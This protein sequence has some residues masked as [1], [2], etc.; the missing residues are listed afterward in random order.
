MYRT[1]RGYFPIMPT[2]YKEDGEVDLVSMRRLTDFLVENGA[3]G[4]SPNGGD[5]EARHLS[6]EERMR[7]TDVVLEANAGRT[8]VLVGTTAH[9]LEESARLTRHAQQAGAD[10]V[11]VMPSWDAWVSAEK[12]GSNKEAVAG[13]HETML[14]R[15]EEICQGLDIPVM[16]HA[17]RGMDR[18]FM[19]AVIE[20]VPNVR[21]IKEETSHGRVLREYVAELGDRVVIFGPGL[22]Y[23][24]E[25]G[26]GALGVMPSCCAPG[27]HARVFDLWQEGR[28]DEARQEWNRLLPL[29]FWRWHTS[30]Q[31][32]GKLYLQEL[33]I[34]E[35]S[36]VRP[37]FGTHRLDEADREE[38][39]T[40]LATMGV[41]DR[42]ASA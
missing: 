27:L 23:P 3:Q 37:T 4:M 12:A 26:W 40:V 29:V 18:A 28:H 32:A 22:H 39:L 21:Y 5:S 42:L 15:Y 8:P 1:L 6:G 17:V 16:I 38:L 7:V 35:T 19:E 31:E 30:S 2:A 11:F 34:F 20:R 33:G 9:T 24:A 36:Y 13:S 10:A 25:L 41:D 14:T